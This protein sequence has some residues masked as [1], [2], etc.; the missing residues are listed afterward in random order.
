MLR[1]IRRL[2]ELSKT[3]GSAENLFK[4]SSS[5]STSSS[6]MS[7]N[8]FALPARYGDGEKSV[9]YVFYNFK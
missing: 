1:N 2:K 7:G 9:W 8:K 3:I 6:T 4:F 5:I